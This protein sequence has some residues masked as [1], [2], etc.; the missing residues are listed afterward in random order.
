MRR[1]RAFLLRLW[2]RVFPDSTVRCEGC[3]APAVSSS[4]EEGP[5]CEDCLWSR[6]SVRSWEDCK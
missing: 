3:G 5:V 6:M 1:I 2:R 4:L